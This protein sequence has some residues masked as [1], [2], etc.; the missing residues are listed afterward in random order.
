MRHATIPSEGDIFSV[1]NIIDMDEEALAALAE[2]SRQRIVE[3]LDAAPRAVG[4]VASA[5]GLRQPQATKHLQALER[6]GLVE[7]HPLGRR[8]IYALRRQPLRD[9]RDWFARFEPDHPSERVLEEYARAVALERGYDRT[10]RL[11]RTIAAPRAGLWEAWTT[12]ALIRRWWHPEHFTVAECQA[13]AVPGGALRIVLREGDGARHTA[14]GHYLVVE[15]PARLVFTL[16]PLTAGRRPLFHATHRLTLT[17]RGPRT[18]LVL[19]IEIS[20]AV[21]GAEPALAGIE[22][23]WRQL[24]DNLVRE[25]ATSTA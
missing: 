7:A 2:P 8:R 4:E 21:P 25:L 12:E 5:L 3:L 19:E 11:T 14:A 22:I 18:Q 23:G 24:L 15:P 10:V 9:L 6:A 20:G 1:G 13:D 17:P 16:D